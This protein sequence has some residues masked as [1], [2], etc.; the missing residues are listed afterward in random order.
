M[1]GGLRVVVLAPMVPSGQRH[2]GGGLEMD[3][4]WMDGLMKGGVVR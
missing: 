1:H 4:G 3:G 2:G